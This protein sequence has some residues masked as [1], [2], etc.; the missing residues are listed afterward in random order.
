MDTPAKQRY[1]LTE[2]D[3]QKDSIYCHHDLMGELLIPE[4][5][6][7]K[8]Q[9]LYTEGGI[10]YVETE[11]KTYFLPARHFMWIPAGVKHSIHPNNENVMM[12]NLYFPVEKEDLPFYNEEGVYPVNDLMLN[13][14]LFTNRWNGNLAKDSRNYT[15]A[16]ALKIILSEISGANLSLSLPEAKD[17]RLIKV[18][19]YVTGHLHD[20]LTFS[21]LAERF[22]FS[23]RTLHRLFKKDIGISFIQY[24]TICRMLRAIELLQQRDMPVSEIALAVGYSSL[25]T[26]SNTFYKVLGQRPTDYVNG[27]D[28]LT[29][30]V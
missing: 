18:T 15:I 17:K 3:V 12:R 26:F 2:V 20:N 30:P 13:L 29:T 23:S 21:A 19:D 14:L 24:F 11:K 5:Q 22:G 6:H 9:F 1:Y 16:K 8:A 27:R 10:V 7:E 28:I 4:H 25:P